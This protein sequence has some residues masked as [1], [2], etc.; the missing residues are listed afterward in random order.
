VR[1]A[2]LRRHADEYLARYGQQNYDM[3]LGDCL[4]YVYAMI[5]KLTGRAVLLA[6]P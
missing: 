2:R 4:W 5:G 3:M 1:A 6:K